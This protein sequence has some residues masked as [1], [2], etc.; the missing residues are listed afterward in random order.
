MSRSIARFLTA[1]VRGL[2]TP[3][4]HR[5]QRRV[6]ARVIEN[7]E[8][9]DLAEVE[10]GR[11]TLLFKQLRGSFVASA[12][13][14][15]HTDEPETLAWIDSFAPGETLW[16]VGANVGLYSLYSGL[17][18]RNPVL[19]FEPSGF[20]FGLLV[21]H[22]ALNGLGRF[23]SPFCVALGQ[24]ERR[25]AHLHMRHTDAGHGSNALGEARNTFGAFEAVFEQAIPA[26]SVDDFRELFSLPAP[27]HIK[28]DVDGIEVDIV[29]GAEKTL[30]AV[31]SLLIEIEGETGL[32]HAAEIEQRL[33]VA[34]L[35][36]V[37]EVRAQGSRR[38]RLYRRDS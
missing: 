9:L 8:R 3:L 32:T 1:V 6:Y 7:L 36:E 17:G 31:K 24:V 23:V 14:R 25:L 12:V 2:A 33:A 26:C 10:T 11:G 34:G 5:Q 22:V 37:V 20:N 4:S 16:D 18:G 30:P 15:F 38:N 29:R 35:H 28:I 21:E 27:D 19:A 13:S